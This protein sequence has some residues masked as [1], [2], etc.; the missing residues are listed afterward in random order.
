MIES[1]VLV[2]SLVLTWWYQILSLDN[3]QLQFSIVSFMF[4]SRNNNNISVEDH[5]G[6]VPGNPLRSPAITK[7]SKWYR[8]NF[9]VHKT[10][11]QNLEL[12]S[13]TYHAN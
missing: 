3:R 5:R 6:H 12:L 10:R 8:N 11:H 1:R 4:R 13:S 7:S 2:D 9:L